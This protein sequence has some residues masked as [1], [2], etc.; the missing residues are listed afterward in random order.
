[1]CAAARDGF[2]TPCRPHTKRSAGLHP[3]ESDSPFRPRSEGSWNEF[4]ND[5]YPCRTITP[6]DGLPRNAHST[7]NH[8][9]A[10]AAWDSI[11]DIGHLWNCP[12]LKVADILEFVVLA[13]LMASFCREY[14]GW[15]SHCLQT[16]LCDTSSLLTRQYWWK[17][18][19]TIFSHLMPIETS[20]TNPTS[21]FQLFRISKQGTEIISHLLYAHIR[22]FGKSCQG[23]LIRHHHHPST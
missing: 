16:R 10:S 11:D 23:T 22:A 9:P 20:T 13:P 8:L 14:T 6:P 18:N 4:V 7:V 12:A 5:E 21:T 19:K 17:I 15:S 3:S 2:R 1:M